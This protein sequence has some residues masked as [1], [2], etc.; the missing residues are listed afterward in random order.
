M[1]YR[2]RKWNKN[3]SGA[4]IPLKENCCLI[5]NVAIIICVQQK[6]QKQAI[7]AINKEPKLNTII[8]GKC[9]HLV[10]HIPAC[11]KQHI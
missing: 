2:V 7:N 10:K 6:Q 1:Y 9:F 5:K 11:D 3:Y 4:E 8:S